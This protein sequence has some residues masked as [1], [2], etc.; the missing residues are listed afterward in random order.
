MRFLDRGKPRLPCAPRLIMTRP[1]FQDYFGCF[2]EEET[3]DHLLK[4]EK[5]VSTMI[6]KANASGVRARIAV[7]LIYYSNP[8]ML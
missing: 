8:C 3:D 1:G 4:D 6:I 7:F 5:M 2:A